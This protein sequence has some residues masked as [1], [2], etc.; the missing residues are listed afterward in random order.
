MRRLVLSALLLG[1]ASLLAQS[2]SSQIVLVAPPAGANCP[3]A[4]TAKHSPQ[5]ATVQIHSG[6]KH[7]EPGYTLTFT[8]LNAH[9]ITQ[10][11]LTLHGLDGA[12]MVPAANLT[13]GNTTEDLTISPTTTDHHRFESIV[14]AQKLTGV[15]LIELDEVTWA[16][17]T[18]WQK[19]ANSTCL[20]TPEHLLLINGAAH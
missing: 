13:T 17:G 7:A 3:V 18:H 14:Y 10:V 1:S 12:Q 4:L 8:P 6:A 20:V 9:S 5:G 16:D 11:K 2:N 15:Q 19:S